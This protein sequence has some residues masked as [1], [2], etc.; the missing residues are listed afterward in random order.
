MRLCFDCGSPIPASDDE[1]PRC[2]S[3]R[4][5]NPDPL[6]GAV[7]TD[8]YEIEA[9]LGTGGMCDVYRARHI[10]IGKAVAIKVLHP[11][12]TADPKVVERFEQEA[13]A[14]SLVHHPNAITIM[15]YGVAAGNTPF[16]V[17]ELIEG[18]TVRQLLQR[19]GAMT[20]E[21][22]AGIITQACG[23]LEAAHTVGVIHRDIKP[24]NIIISEVDG[25]DWVEVVDF[26]IAKIQED[27]SRRTALTGANL[28]LGTPQYMSPEQAEEKPVDARSDIYSLGVVVY[29][30][31]AG[32]PPFSGN[33]TTRLLIAHAVEPPPPLIN[34]RPDIPPGV[35]AVVTRAL[36]KDPARRQQSALE[37]AR[38]FVSAAEDARLY[39]N[40]MT[41]PLSY[42]SGEPLLAGVDLS[43]QGGTSW[44]LADE[45]EE[46]LVRRG[47]QGKRQTAVFGSMAQNVSSAPPA[48]SQA[49]R[50]GR[51][52]GP[53]PG[54]A[55][56]QRKGMRV[57]LFAGLLVVLL[58]A[59]VGVYFMIHR[60]S[61]PDK[62]TVS[63]EPDRAAATNANANVPAPALVQADEGQPEAASGTVAAANDNASQAAP[64]D[65]GNAINQVR[66][67]VTRWNTAL[68][69]RDL[70]GYISYYAPRLHT[71]FL[72]DNVDRNTARAE[73]AS[74]MARYSKLKISASPLTVNV[75]PSGTHAIVTYEKS[76][77]FEG[78]QPWSG[79]A[80]ERLWLDR[81]DGRWRISG[82]RDLKQIR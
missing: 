79:A 51:P 12:F 41:E 61:S 23:A 26:G 58:A 2:G 62:P 60:S 34:Q 1:C 65:V 74:A 16:L 50:T 80:V 21:R 6:I 76:W 52:T 11:E 33:S 48:N 82:V 72:K 43:P 9:K 13:R 5:E 66:D 3:S 40:Q 20:A 35:A 30:M 63:Q 75:D 70:N 15:D 47:A 68:E 54:T 69:S 42:G 64:V 55:G 57:A 53:Q 77:D 14:A 28:I 37:F 24:Q 46:T 25:R 44:L 36:E 10:R 4:K 56:D 73:V 29:E 81:V 27:V 17:M 31:L 8:K 39:G 32:A 45:D 19:Y 38:E 67:T 78:K 7:F 71:Y 59:V 49:G 22:A 18:A